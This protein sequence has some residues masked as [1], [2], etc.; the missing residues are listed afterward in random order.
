MLASFALSGHVVTTGPRGLTTPPLLIHAAMAAFWVGSLIPLH[1]VLTRPAGEAHSYVERFSGMAI[2]AVPVLIAAG[3]V[4][5]WLQVRRP[6]ALVATTYGRVLLF[7]LGLVAALLGLAALNR[8]RL[9]PALARSDPRAVAH[10]GRSILA[11]AGLVVAI[12]VATATL[13]TTLPPRALGPVAGAEASDLHAHQ[14]H[15]H[16]HMPAERRLHLSGSGLQA[17][18]VLEP[19]HNGADAA[20]ICLRDPQGQPLDVLEVTLRLANPGRGIAPLERPA[21]RDRVG[22]WRVPA[23]VLA[24][25]GEWEVELDVLISDFERQTRRPDG[26]PAASAPTRLPAMA[27]G[28]P[29]SPMG[30]TGSSAPASRGAPASRSRPV[31]PGA[32][33]LSGRHGQPKC[34]H[35]PGRRCTRL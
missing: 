20:A 11:E 7:K 35:D 21:E 1:R 18:L 30:Q 16:G 9:T 10:L 28:L 29:P 23:V 3:L 13:G 19:G 26:V 24:V 25:A 31:R 22:H 15:G 2:W 34:T 27:D 12:L 33:R 8:V 5:T 17:T 6:E 32:Q 14:E 4:I